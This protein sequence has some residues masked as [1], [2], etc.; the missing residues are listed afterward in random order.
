MH[1]RLTEL[2]GYLE[3]ER[4]DLIA[5]A[6]V[7]PRER[8]IER[9][10]PDR[11]AVSEVLCHLHKVE[12]GVAKLINKRVGEARAVGHPAEAEEG[13]LLGALDGRGIS[14]RSIRLQAPSQVAPTETPDADTVKQ[15]LDESRAMLR[16]AIASADG[17]ALAAITHPHPV[18]GEIN[19]YQWILFVGQH[20][21]RHADQITEVV[22]AVAA[23]SPARD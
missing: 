5:A 12:R 14:S 18:L 20:E 21:R 8:W 11:W 3:A 7:L 13:S 2:L 15:Q 19:L 17:L 6:S 22:T 9:P 4:R 1:S 10:A 16:E 23:P